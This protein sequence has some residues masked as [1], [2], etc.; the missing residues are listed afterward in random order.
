MSIFCRLI[1]LNRI[2]C[3]SAAL[4]CTGVVVSDVPSKETNKVRINVKIEIDLEC[5]SG[6]GFSPGI[7]RDYETIIGD[8]RRAR[9]RILHIFA[10]TICLNA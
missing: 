5:G 8:L 7:N 10:Y 3:G 4:A 9:I 6:M 2:S 1:P